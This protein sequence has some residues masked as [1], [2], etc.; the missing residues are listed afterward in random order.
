[1]SVKRAA[2]VPRPQPNRLW[3]AHSSPKLLIRDGL[4]A[5]YKYARKSLIFYESF[6]L[7]FHQ[8]D[9]TAGTN[10]CPIVTNL[11]G[12]KYHGNH[13]LG[14][15]P[16]SRISAEPLQHAF[17]RSEGRRGPVDDCSLCAGC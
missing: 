12:G 15:I 2:C 3:T 8:I 11:S 6:V 5:Y 10:P 17:P 13:S 16:R 4:C 9:S 1:M 14:S 7:W